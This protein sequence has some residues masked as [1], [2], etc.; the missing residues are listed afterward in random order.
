MATPDPVDQRGLVERIADHQ[1]SADQR[2]GRDLQPAL[3]TGGHHA[4]CAP[5]RA[6]LLQR[7]NDV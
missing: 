3:I 6:M 2:R 7:D 5:S 1:S 4:S